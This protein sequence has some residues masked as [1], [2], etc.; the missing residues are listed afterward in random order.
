MNT[1]VS[2]SFEQ[3]RPVSRY[4]GWAVIC[5]ISL[6]MFTLPGQAQVTEG[7]PVS[8]SLEEIDY[9]F[10]VAYRSFSILGRDVR[11]AYMDVSPQGEPNGETVVLLHGLNFFGYYWGGTA[12]ALRSEG[13]RVIIPDQIGF[14]KSSKPIVPYSFQEHAHNTRELLRELGIR[15]AHIVG[16]SMGGMVATRFAFS[17]PEVSRSLVLVN[18]IGMRDFRLQRPFQPTQA[19]YES[20]LERDLEQ[21][22]SGIE[23][24]FVEW[25]PEY[26]FFVR[27]HHGWT[28]SA[29]WPRLAMVRAL[30][31]QMVYSQPVA[32]EFAHVQ[33]PAYIL[34][35]AED[36][37][38]YPEM[39]RE[40]LE[41]LPDG[42]L[43]LFENVGHNPHLESPEPFRAELIRWLERVE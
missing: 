34:S 2:N 29:E 24:Y 38:N 32:Y 19:I 28:L 43:H 41:K 35:G 25:D 20:N 37:P 27:V 5:M 22:R 23:A 12:E 18:M 14:G 17:Y 3:V 9:P 21:I 13:Y 7:E 42:E 31:Q 10:P 8:I 4:A 11:M 30:N 36:G 40:V 1:Q 26:E 33:V 6:L 39:A 15:Q 16:H